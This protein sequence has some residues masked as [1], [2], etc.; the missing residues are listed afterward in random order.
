MGWPVMWRL[1]LGKL[2]CL[3]LG[4]TEPTPGTSMLQVT[5]FITK[6]CFEILTL[7][8]NNIRVFSIFFLITEQIN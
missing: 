5:A 6:T 4:R 2:V 7:T 1:S 3:S 8:N